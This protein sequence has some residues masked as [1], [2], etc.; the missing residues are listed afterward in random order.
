MLKKYGAPLEEQIAGLIHDVSHSAFSHCIDYALEGGSEKE[1]N[2]QDKLFDEFVR[3]TEIPGIIK[4]YGFDLEYILKVSVRNDPEDYD[5]VVFRKS[6]IVDPLFIN[7]NGLLKRVSE[8]D[9]EW[10]E[11]VEQ[12]LQP[13]KY[14][15]KFNDQREKN[16]YFGEDR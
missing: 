3:K 14:F 9:S 2:H 15:L 4:K 5:V 12:E 10:K 16:E 6:R 1:Q 11:I 13:K 8:E 7:K